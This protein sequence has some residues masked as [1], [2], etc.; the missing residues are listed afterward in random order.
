MSDNKIHKY[1]SRKYSK[2]NIVGFLNECYIEPFN[3]KIDAYLKDLEIINMER[4]K[5]QQKAHQL[6]DRYRKACKDKLKYRLLAEPQTSVRAQVICLITCRS[7]LFADLTLDPLGPR[8]DCKVAKSWE[9]DRTHKQVHLYQPI[10]GIVN[11]SIN[12]FNGVI[13]GGKFEIVNEQKNP[14]LRRTPRKTN[15]VDYAGNSKRVNKEEIS[16][17]NSEM[18]DNEDIDKKVYDEENTKERKKLEKSS[19]RKRDEYEPDYEGLSLLFDETNKDALVESIDKKVLGQENILPQASDNSVSENQPKNMDAS[20]IE[21]FHEYQKT[22][23]KSYKIFTPAYW[24][25]LDLTGES[26]H[27]CKQ[28]KEEDI[29]QLS[30]DFANKIS[31]KKMPP[32]ENIREY[33]DSNCEKKNDNIKKLAVNI[34][35]MKSDVYSFQGMMTEE[36]L[37]MSSAF[38][39]FRGIFTSDRI[40]NI[41]GEIQALPTNY[42]RNEKGNPFKKARIGRRVDMKSTLFKTS[43]KF[44]VIYGEVAGGLGPLGIPTA[45]RKKRYL[46]KIKL[47]IT[48]RDGINRLLKE[49]K[50]IASEKR[51]NLTIYGW[52][53]FGLELNFYAMD[54]SC[55]GIYRFGLIDQCRLPSDEDEFGMLEDAYCIL[56]LLE[57]KTLEIEK[58]VKQLYLKNK[59]EEDCTRN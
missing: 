22:I 55:S 23:P 58:V 7:R 18:H 29:M 10:N 42:A 41:W 37:K 9:E 36:E 4:G 38:P 17:Q 57:K 50:H 26:L 3:L 19:K 14:P 15:K 53:Q 28:L 25:V 16:D 13:N 21:A 51:M 35:F 56:K 5:R 34:Q 45:C 46:D 47:M 11:G 1:F 30:Q 20:I 8:P 59:R 44:E 40:K 31:W 24:G 39:L 43:N 48:M 12:T 6:L 49:F 52:L 2:W 33:F 27:D 54:W 32:E